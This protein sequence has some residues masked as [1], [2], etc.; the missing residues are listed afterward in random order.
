MIK[1][2]RTTQ[3]YDVE[4]DFS[5]LFTC[6]FR[7]EYCFVPPNKLGEKIRVYADDNQWTDA[8]RRTGKRWLVHITGG[9]P[10]A[11]PRFVQLCRTLTR[12]NLISLNSNIHHRSILQ[13]AETMDPTRVSF[14]NAGFHIAERTKRGATDIFLVHATRLRNAGFRVFVSLVATP[15]VVT[16]LQ[17]YLELIRSAGL[18]VSPKVLRGFFHGGYYPAAYSPAEKAV[19]S[20][21]IR[22]ACSAFREAYSAEESVPTIDI[23]HDDALLDGLPTFSGQSC[24]AGSKFISILPNG[25]VY[26][27]SKKTRLGNLL[28]GTFRFMDGPRACDTRYCVY[29]CKKY[30][31]P[32]IVGDEP[33]MQV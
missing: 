17:E 5:L 9:E 23:F 6:N 19:L 7:C 20:A 4:A 21:G 31:A 32:E 11:Y 24:A 16:K 26:R 33:R 29:F 10:T 8:F 27:C 14:I 13:F 3:L 22:S 2:T 1:P 15:E 18:V 28:D 12:D 25:D 30:T